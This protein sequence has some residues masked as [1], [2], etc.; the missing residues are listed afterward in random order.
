MKINFVSA[1]APWLGVALLATSVAL[2]GCGGGG[3]GP[4]GPTKVTATPIPNPTS[5]QTGTGGNCTNSTFAPNYT[6][7]V[8]LLRWTLF[9][10][11]IY[12]KRDSN[13]SAARQAMAIQG[14][15]RWVAA[16]GSNGFTYQVVSSEAA[17]NVTVD[18]YD[19]KGGPGDTL[20]T[21]VVS[22]FEESS[23][24]DSAD[25]S[26]G[27][28]NNGANDLLTATHEMGHCLGIF[29]HSPNRTDLMF[30]E[31][32]EAAGGVI[33]PLDLNTVLTAYC[34][35]FNKN[36]NARLSTHSGELKTITIH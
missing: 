35:N 29:G 17:S 18:F 14:F 16:T 28:T 11:R 20:G 21:T 4:A 3:G 19:F 23:T 5:G 12:F 25:I 2:S 26:L 34:G 9:P 32:N 24:I 13:Y 1:R 33:T 6:D 30:F 15:D 10:L 31:G 36:S 8:R 22:Y 7:S 27:I